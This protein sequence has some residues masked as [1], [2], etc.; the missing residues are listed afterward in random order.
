[1]VFAELY[2]CFGVALKFAVIS[3]KPTKHCFLNLLV[4]FFLEEIVIEELH[5]P[6][7]DQFALAG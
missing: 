7:N 6:N 5:R 4:V 1:M 3:E 2:F